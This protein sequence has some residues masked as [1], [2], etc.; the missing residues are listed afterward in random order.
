M[1][2]RQKV[3]LD[4]GLE[5]LALDLASPPPDPLAAL[6]PRALDEVWLEV[7]FG[8]GE[9]LL[10]Q[11][12][13]NPN[14]G[15][16]ACEPFIDGVVKVI[17]GADRRGLDNIRI[18]AD[19]VRTVLEWMPA[20]AISRAFILFPDPWPKARHHKRRLVDADFVAMLARVMKPGSELRLATDIPDYA[21]KMLLAV[22]S[23]PRFAWTA[24]RPADWR[25]RPAD[26]PATRYEAKAI[27]E[28]RNRYFLR[29]THCG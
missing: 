19:D 28:G 26:W 2:G 6:F 5:A 7:G 24:R 23:D 21:R 15:F 1:T 18:Y 13:N 12:Q 11:A 29:F 14:V 20:A 16:I 17:D 4:Q 8:G 22:R 25:E 3:L 27:R 9:H 10:W